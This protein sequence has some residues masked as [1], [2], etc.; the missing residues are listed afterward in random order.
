MLL[1][2][3]TL[4]KRDDV[5]AVVVGDGREGLPRRVVLLARVAEVLEIHLALLP[6]LRLH[7]VLFEDA[8]AFL[9]RERT[10]DLETAGNGPCAE[11][12]VGLRQRVRR[13]EVEAVLRHVLEVGVL[14]VE[15]ACL[16]LCLFLRACLLRVVLVGG[17]L[18]L[19]D[20]L[21]LAMHHAVV[22]GRILL[23][24][25]REERKRSCVPAGT[26]CERRDL[27][28]RAAGLQKAALDELLPHL[29]IR[30]FDGS[31]GLAA[32]RIGVL[33]ARHI[34]F[35]VR[36]LEV[37]GRLRVEPD[38]LRQFFRAADEERGRRAVRRNRKH[39]IDLDGLLRCR[40]LA[41]VV[42]D[43][44]LRHSVM[45]AR[46]VCGLLHHRAEVIQ[47]MCA[48]LVRLG[49]LV[50]VDRRKILLVR[51]PRIRKA[52]LS[53][54][55]ADTMMLFMIY[56]CWMLG[57]GCAAVVLAAGCFDVSPRM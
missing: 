57:E 2:V 45:E 47:S 5:A 31:A 29:F 27:L 21:I 52:V 15:F 36:R 16:C 19:E 44:L 56:F 25:L 43:R 34:V 17:E 26:I 46:S 10:V 22:R 48:F 40:A 28:R 20:D 11:L 8:V 18:A 49:V 42:G 50:A 7:A 14:Q 51:F 24:A 54:R 6:R 55:T 39:F 3:E 12:R 9:L 35:A 41:G 38:A 1:V 4:G 13:V 33:R 32:L 30:D 37:V 53:F 23:A